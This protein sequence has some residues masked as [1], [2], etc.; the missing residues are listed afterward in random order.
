MVTKVAG[1]DL[2]AINPACISFNAQLEDCLNYSSLLLFATTMQAKSTKC[3]MSTRSFCQAIPVQ[4]ILSTDNTTL[5]TLLTARALG[6]TTALELLAKAHGLE[7][8]ISTVC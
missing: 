3:S 7:A 6:K 1:K 8:G 2:C 5:Y 4:V